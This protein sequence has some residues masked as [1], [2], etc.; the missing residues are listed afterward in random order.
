MDNR[1]QE[2]IVIVADSRGTQLEIL[3]HAPEGFT[4][5]VYV[6]PG[7]TLN[8]LEGRLQELLFE[9]QYVLA[10]LFGGICSITK[11][12]KYTKVIYL[13][14]QGYDQIIE[15]TVSI[16]DGVSQSLNHFTQTP[17]VM[18]P[19]TGVDLHRANEWEGTHPLQ[20]DLDWAV[21]G[22]N[23]FVCHL[24]AARGL[25]TPWLASAIHRC[26]GAKWKHSYHKLEDGVHPSD[27]VL[28]YWAK[29][30][31]INFHE[32]VKRMFFP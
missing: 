19:I 3:L 5:E 7:A 31:N 9:K 24:N 4:V 28:D 16:L 11:R 10:Y 22:I 18:C 13:Q 8:Y 23:R 32:N 12:N 14:H 29:H 6:Y 17:I 25:A 15:N 27:T 26:H 2:K 30:F 20:G 21:L 1:E